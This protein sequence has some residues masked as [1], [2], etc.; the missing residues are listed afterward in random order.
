MFLADTNAPWIGAFC[1]VK[2]SYV[3]VVMRA[4]R[5][6]TL[7]PFTAAGETGT[8]ALKPDAHFNTLYI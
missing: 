6:Y 2:P 5:G 8:S 4:Q 3:S 1:T 7:Y